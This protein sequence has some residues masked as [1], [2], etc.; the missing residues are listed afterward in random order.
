MK[1]RILAVGAFERDNFGDLL[2]LAVLRKIVGNCAEIVP[3]SIIF[4][5]MRNVFN[6]IVYP[7]DLML[8]K[9]AWDAVWV[10][11]GE[12]GSVDIENA[13]SM[14][15][16][17]IVD[18]TNISRLGQNEKKQL[19]G[20]LNA[21]TGQQLAYI[22][23]LMK[24]KKNRKTKVVINSVG[25]HRLEKMREPILGDTIE[26]LKYANLS[27]RD[28]ESD[29][30]CKKHDIGHTLIPDVVHA[31]SK[32]YPKKIFKQPARRYFVFQASLDSLSGLKSYKRIVQILIEVAEMLNADVVF[33]PAGI[34]YRHDS[35]D[36][37]EKI[38]KEFN[39]ASRKYAA[40]IFTE[41]DPIKIAECIA[42]SEM[43]IATS[44]HCRVVSESYKVK[45]ITLK[46]VNRKTSNYAKYWDSDFPSDVDINRLPEVV[47]A[48]KSVKGS[49][50]N[51]KELR[52]LADDNAEKL[53]M[54][55]IDG[56]AATGDDSHSFSTNDIINLMEDNKERIFQIMK[57][58]NEKDQLI[59][60]KDKQI[61]NKDMEIGRL[62]AELASFLSIK[63]AAH[64]LA[65]N[66]RRRIR[67]GK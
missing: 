26:L 21:P 44:L 9:C 29:I 19:F 64:R 6:E 45:R 35:T 67:N 63:R 1:K 27:V 48:T 59:F 11:G 5:D 10:V 46:N 62:N 17:H 7:Y 66:V 8:R 33:L 23:N 12:I 37:Y 50:S 3:A 55:I 52:E 43:C 39:V 20:L 34:T 28:I 14:D 22:P 60:D 40:N 47:A 13:L 51:N 65:D 18:G 38:V 58:F 49:F 57:I 36:A 25:I 53:L 15:L 4:S 54:Q 2:F 30:F 16:P 61:A 32:Y 42:M 41:R 56:Q 24:Y 31:V